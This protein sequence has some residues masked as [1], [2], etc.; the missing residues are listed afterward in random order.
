MRNSLTLKALRPALIASAMMIAISGCNQTTRLGPDDSTVVSDSDPINADGN[1]GNTGG[2][3]V[4]PA[5]ADF[6]TV[7][8]QV[9]QRRC[10]ACHGSSGGVNLQTYS[11]VFKNKSRVRAEVVQGS[12]PPGSPLS[13][14]QR[15]LLVNWIDAGAPQ[16]PAAAATATAGV[17]MNEDGTLSPTG[18]L[19]E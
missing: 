17:M 9:L 13:S 2:T 6:A 16:S 5:I 18:S 11:N 19:N 8:S 10:V 12:M 14:S 3:G 1:T 7:S 15:K 4:S